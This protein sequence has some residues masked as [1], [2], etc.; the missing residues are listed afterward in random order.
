M[1]KDDLLMMMELTI[2]G[3]VMLVLVAALTGCAGSPRKPIN[4]LDK[5]MVPS[6]CL[7][8]PKAILE[9]SRGIVDEYIDLVTQ[10]TELAVTYNQCKASLTGEK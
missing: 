4:S 10:Y 2:S 7:D 3:I 1:K 5:V 6:A 9:P 8:S